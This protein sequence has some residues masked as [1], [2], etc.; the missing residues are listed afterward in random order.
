MKILLDSCVWG[1]AKDILEEAGHDTKWAGDLTEDPGDEAILNIAEKE[2]R[3]LITLDKDFGELAI[4]HDKPHS[5]IIRLVGHSALR[6]GPVSVKILQKYEHELQK[7]A[8]LTVEKSRVRIR[9][10]NL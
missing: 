2:Q 7:N 9:S 10:G 6:Q 3:V 4:V 8:I 5:G 1:G